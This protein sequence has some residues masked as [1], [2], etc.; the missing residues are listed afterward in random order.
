[1]ERRLRSSEEVMF[2]PDHSFEAMEG[3]EVVAVVEGDGR[4]IGFG[5]GEGEGLDAGAG[6][7]AGMV[8]EELLA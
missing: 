7:A 1:M 8:T 4:G 6:D 5:D 2:V 3:G